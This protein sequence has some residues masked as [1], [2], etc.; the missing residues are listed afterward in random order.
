[1]RT[2]QTIQSVTIQLKS[3]L[4][5]VGM[6]CAIAPSHAYHIWGGTMSYEVISIAG[7]MAQVRFRMQI[8]RGEGGNGPGGANFDNP[9]EFGVW[10]L[11]GSEYEYVRSFGVNFQ[12]FQVV[13]YPIYDTYLADEIYTVQLGWYEAVVTIPYDGSDYFL[14]YR[15]CCRFANLTNIFDADNPED[16]QMGAEYGIT[17]TGRAIELGNSSPVSDIGWDYILNVKDS[18]FERSMAFVDADGDSLVY[19]F[20]APRYG[21]GIIGATP[22]SGDSRSCSGIRPDPQNCPPLIKKADYLSGYSLERPFGLNTEVTLDFD[23]GLLKGAKLSEGLFTVGIEISEYRQGELLSTTNVDYTYYAAEIERINE[24]HGYRFADFNNNG[25]W[26][27]E[28][29]PVKHLTLSFIPGAL[30]SRYF[31]D[32]AYS[33]FVKDGTYSVVSS[34][35]IFIIPD[36]FMIDVVGTGASIERDIPFVPIDSTM[37]SIPNIGIAGARCNRPARLNLSVLNAGSLMQKGTV[38]IRIDS[39]TSFLSSD[40]PNLIALDEFNYQF[41]F[42]S[43]LPLSTLSHTMKVDLPDATFLGDTMIFEM[44]L[45]Y[46]FVNDPSNSDTV[47]TSVKNILSCSIDP[48]AKYNYPNRGAESTTYLGEEIFYNITFQNLGNDTAYDVRI[49]DFLNS[50]L[51]LSTISF[52]GGS[53]EY[54]CEQEGRM[55][56]FYFNGIN[57]PPA[58]QDSVRSNGYIAF[59]AFPIKNA[60]VGSKLNNAAKIYFDQNLPIS[61][62]TVYNTISV[63]LGNE[64]NPEYPNEKKLLIFPNPSTGLFQFVMNESLAS[65]AEI[66]V[67]D[68]AGHLVLRNPVY[69]RSFYLELDAIPATY[70]YAI[71]DADGNDVY[72]GILV[73]VR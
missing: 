44:E 13:T 65:P 32:G 56:T 72:T 48:N 12:E 28:E 9:A 43:L 8:A 61:T 33:A 17:I 34:D 22:I 10:R 25:V 31:S 50:S 37:R 47:N 21:G 29:P 38:N 39:I 54:Y 6:L 42:D 11:V 62:N 55:L 60:I 30:R 67:F 27:V 24:I 71:V 1:M 46:E 64:S 23:T 58:S 51:D 59:S 52:Q 63:H 26:D 3:I 40:I 41:I 19:A 18:I 57:L 7:D 69:A 14:G 70:Y 53:H 36:H 16:I 5:I 45:L 20:G 49:T 15:R 4:I 35:T 2:K 73:L 68:L 66:Y